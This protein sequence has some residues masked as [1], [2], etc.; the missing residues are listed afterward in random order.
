MGK[1]EK[2][3]CP[4]K[5]SLLGID[6]SVAEMIRIILQGRPGVVAVTG[7]PGTGKTTM[8]FSIAR[9]AADMGLPIS[10]VLPEEYMGF[11][12]FPQEWT[13]HLGGDT[14]DSWAA[15][16]NAACGVEHSGVVVEIDSI[17]TR[18]GVG[19][20][21]RI[22]EEVKKSRWIFSTLET[23]LIGIDIAYYLQGLGLSSQEI[24]DSLSGI[25]SMILAPKLC[26]ECREQVGA[27]IEDTHLIYPDAEEAGLVWKA[28][29]CEKC[30]YRGVKGKCP[31]IAVVQVD[32]Q[33]RRV[34][35][36]Y[37]KDGWVAQLPAEKYISMF[38]S[39]RKMAQKGI[40][41]IDTYKRVVLQNPLLRSHQLLEQE[42]YRSNRIKKMF[43]RFVTQQVAE[44][45]IAC[46]DIEQIV[47]GD[48]RRVTCLFC[49]IRGFTPYAEVTTPV[50]LF[51]LLNAHFGEIIDIVFEYEGTID[52]FIGDSVMVVFGAPMP[53]EDQELRAVRCAIDIQRKVAEVNTKNTNSTP[54]HVGISLNTGEVAA[55]C[56]GNDRRMDYTV[57]GDTVN[58]ASRLEEIAEPGQ[59]VIGPETA[60][61]V[62][63]VVNICEIRT[64]KLKGKKEPLKV[65]EVIYQDFDE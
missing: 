17:F 12:D 11:M 40:I 37:L 10:L 22:L 23:P 36:A 58:T 63:G 1:S 65:F 4:L 53:Q 15:A 60:S 59:I 39:A 13:I 5:L 29:G 3:L 57:L 64:F 19:T 27:D 46:E 45:L 43:S 48:S 14:A 35:E 9:E 55:G 8:L 47:K 2:L 50:K 32:D 21:N 44:S 16:F 26:S 42:Q 33:V 61:A 25:V 41:D 28:V 51:Q 18:F 56:L 52:K 30:E 7:Q 6:T 31:P 49:D 34:I 54:I 62:A 24:V 38:A 20:V